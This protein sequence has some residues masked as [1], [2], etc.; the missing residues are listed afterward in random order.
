[1]KELSA[2]NAIIRV[3]GSVLIGRTGEASARF[4]NSGKENVFLATI[5]WLARRYFPLWKKQQGFFWH[6]AIK[7]RRTRG[8]AYAECAP[9]LAVRQ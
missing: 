2:N 7:T 6:E 9:L 5:E 8:Y 3:S 1:L 4:L